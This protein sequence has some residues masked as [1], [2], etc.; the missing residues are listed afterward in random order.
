MLVGKG[1]A[2][3]GIFK[4]NDIN[5]ML[6][7]SAYL[8]EFCELWHGIL[9]HIYYN[10]VKHKANLGLINNLTNTNNGKCVIY[11]KCKVTCT[12]FKSV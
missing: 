12:S 3:F 11:S 9:G 4:L 8:I 1:S 7:T 10:N 2:Q 5:E 6:F